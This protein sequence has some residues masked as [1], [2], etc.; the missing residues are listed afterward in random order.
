MSVEQQLRDHFRDDPA[1]GV[2]GPDLESVLDRGRRRRRARVAG[3]A[4]AAGAAAAAV[5]VGAVVTA[6]L[7]GGDAPPTVS[8][9]DRGADPAAGSP[10][11]VTGTDV[12][13]T[14]QQV[15]ADHLPALGDAA[16]VYPSDWFADGPIP[17]ADFADATDWQAAYPVADGERALVLM[18]YPKPGEPTGCSVCHDETVPGGTL[19][20]QVTRLQGSG[21]WL[22][23]TSLLRDD[24]FT[25]GV[26]DYVT[27]DRLAEAKQARSISDD[28]A[29]TV[30][31]DP[32]M[33]FDPPA[34]PPTGP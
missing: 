16:D 27:A 22:F 9:P 19:R 25:V 3:F 11:F 21:E 4:G 14:I 5:T 8:V 17:D 31:R 24:G 34:D 28:D 20:T 32:R 12:D 15:V 6:S 10:D 33:H 30:V 7:V 29:A 1:E 2:G 13:E 18:G 26:I 23:M